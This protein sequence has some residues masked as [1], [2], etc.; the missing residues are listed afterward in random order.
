MASN[1]VFEPTR[2][3]PYTQPLMVLLDV[4]LPIFVLIAIGY[5]LGRKGHLTPEPLSKLTFWVLTPTL[6]FVTLSKNALQLE[7]F[8]QLAAFVTLFSLAFWLIAL[9]LGRLLQLKA[10]TTAALALGLVF[11]N[12]GNYGLPFLLFALGQSG[13][14]LGVL[15]IAISSFLMATLG[16]VIATWGKGWSMRPFLNVFKTPLFYGVCLALLL[17]AANVAL[18]LFILRPLDLLSQATI[19]MMLILLGVQL[20]GVEVGQRWRLIGTATA[21]RLVGGPLIALL[22]VAWLGMDGLARSVAVLDSGMP[23]AVNALVLASYYRRDPPLVASV[24]LASTLFSA[25]SLTLL[26]L[27]IQG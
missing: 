20:V 19:P 16:V 8:A 3:T 27:W 1:R 26:L 23:T 22:L 7:I 5:A 12:N 18:P 13:F 14:N 2:V 21:L 4:L 25:L 17:K 15:Y 24:V 9:G 11:A 6:L 10:D